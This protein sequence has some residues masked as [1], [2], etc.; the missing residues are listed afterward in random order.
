MSGQAEDHE[1]APAG[2]ATA[3]S[4]SSTTATGANRGV[5]VKAGAMVVAI[6]LAVVLVKT[7]TTP[8]PANLR[9]DLSAA[10]KAQFGLQLTDAEARCMV[11]AGYGK[12]VDLAALTCLRGESRRYFADVLWRRV[13]PVPASTA[14]VE[15]FTTWAMRDALAE[16]LADIARTSESSANAVGLAGDLVDRN[17]LRPCV[18]AG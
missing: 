15:C 10:V 3:S 1:P 16:Q 13:A 18:T 6:I 11:G 5:W 8:R 7:F 12:Y 14:Q 17:G 9:R 2:T 4:A